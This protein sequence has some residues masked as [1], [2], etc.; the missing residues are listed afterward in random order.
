MMRAVTTL[1]SEKR[2][3]T[4]RF[5]PRDVVVA[6]LVL[7]AVAAV[8]LFIFGPVDVSF[9][10]ASSPLGPA[11]GW[12][13]DVRSPLYYRKVNPPFGDPKTNY[14][15]RFRP[16]AQFRFGVGIENRGSHP[17]R[18]EGIV[19]D[20]E[21]RGMARV[22]GMRFQHRRNAY[23]LEGATSDPLVI[24]PR[25]TGFVIPVVQTGASCTR[26]AEE[27][28]DSIKLR[29]SY[30][31]KQTTERYSLPV[32]VGIACRNARRLVDGVVTP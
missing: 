18:I 4:R 15:L 32:V 10:R 21:W 29:Y 24:E 19:P 17:L 8:L 20:T 13:P 9:G 3:A 23:V 31:G 22:T 28:F 25:G 5:R 14:V 30:R 16:H 12:A 6:A 11:N 27:Y 26:D 2:P 7:A 1:A